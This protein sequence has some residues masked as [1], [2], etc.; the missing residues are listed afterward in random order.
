MTTLADITGGGVAVLIALADDPTFR[1]TP[2][3][4]PLV[5]M[6]LAR[7]IAKDMATSR[8]SRIAEEQLH[9]A[10]DTYVLVNGEWPDYGP[11]EMDADKLAEIDEWESGIDDAVEAVFAPWRDAGAVSAGWL[12]TAAIDT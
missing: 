3:L 6:T 9:A 4:Q 11:A 10:Y 12:F 2:N 5:A 8:L 7:N 1:S